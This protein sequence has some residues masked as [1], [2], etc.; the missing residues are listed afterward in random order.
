M[1]QISGQADDP[2]CDYGYRRHKRHRRWG[3][4]SDESGYDESD[5]DDG[6]A[7][8]TMLEVYDVDVSWGPGRWNNRKPACSVFTGQGEGG[9]RTV[10]A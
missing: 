10:P 2:Y 8:A 4:D 7:S 9:L 1:T 6:G 5:E 3:Y